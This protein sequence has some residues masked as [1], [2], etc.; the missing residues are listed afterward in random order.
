MRSYLRKE[1]W[2]SRPSSAE[3]LPQPCSCVMSQS[4]ADSSEKNNKRQVEISTK[5]RCRLLRPKSTFKYVAF[6]PPERDRPESKNVIQTLLY[7]KD[8]RFNFES[9]EKTEGKHMCNFFFQNGAV[10]QRLRGMEIIMKTAAK[11]QPVI[12]SLLK[13]ED[14]MELESEQ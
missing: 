9:H 12:Q 2:P 1:T 10:L 7:S 8:V 11:S 13:S 14:W 3:F 4:E 5:T 6:A